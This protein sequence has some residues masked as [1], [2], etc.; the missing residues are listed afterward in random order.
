MSGWNSELNR[1]P[2]SMQAG[3]CRGIA[4]QKN[5]YMNTTRNKINK[6]T[7]KKVATTK[8]TPKKAAA[9]TVPTRKVPNRKVP[10]R[11]EANKNRTPRKSEP[12]NPMQE[13]NALQR[14]WERDMAALTKLTESYLAR[15]GLDQS[16]DPRELTDYV[17]RCGVSARQSETLIEWHKTIIEAIKTRPDAA[18][19]AFAIDGHT[20]AIALMRETARNLRARE[21]EVRK[22]LAKTKH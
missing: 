5:V 1:R 4:Q 17:E 8:S 3:A 9:K 18:N 11:K 10:N 13:M 22:L 15:G 14:E 6:A 21:K 16:D 12:Q 19:L 2:V 20:K 7:S